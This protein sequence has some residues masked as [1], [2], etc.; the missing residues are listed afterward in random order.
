MKLE[1][2]DED[3]GAAFITDHWV[4]ERGSP[5][6]CITS[7][8]QEAILK[9]GAFPQALS[10]PWHLGVCVWVCV[11][12]VFSVK[13]GGLCFRP[14]TQLPPLPCYLFPPLLHL[15]AVTVLRLDPVSHLPI[16]LKAENAYWDPIWGWG[17]GARVGPQ[18]GW[19]TQQQHD[20]E[21]EEVESEGERWRTPRPPTGDGFKWL[22]GSLSSF[23]ASSSLSVSLSLCVFSLFLSPFSSI[24]LFFLTDALLT[25]VVLRLGCAARLTLLLRRSRCDQTQCVCVCEGVWVGFFFLFFFLKKP[26]SVHLSLFHTFYFPFSR[27]AKKLLR[28]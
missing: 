3:S 14:E 26:P 17:R 16:H 19:K 8:R 22:P 23:Q 4:S 27:S 10:H 15:P 11:C 7:A 2:D 24:S 21:K 28:L 13:G 18:Q 1:E 25:E 6:R 9:W 20:E 5:G 12:E